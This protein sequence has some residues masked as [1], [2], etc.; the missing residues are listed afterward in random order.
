M[1]SLWRSEYEAPWALSILEETK[2]APFKHF[3]SCSLWKME[4]INQPPKPDNHVENIQ[5]NFLFFFR[6]P[7]GWKFRQPNL[8]LLKLDEE[9]VSSI[10]CEILK[11]KLLHIHFFMMKTI[12]QW[13]RFIQWRTGWFDQSGD[14]TRSILTLWKVN[15][16]QFDNLPTIDYYYPII[17]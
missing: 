15:Y 12:L 4:I 8:Y 6:F 13:I 9:T 14:Q 16:Y 11:S 2:M 1:S 5:N 7:L 17:R 10:S 3:I